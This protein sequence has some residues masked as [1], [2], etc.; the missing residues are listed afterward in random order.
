MAPDVFLPPDTPIQNA[1]EHFGPDL[2][3]VFVRSGQ[4]RLGQLIPNDIMTLLW[5]GIHDATVADIMVP[6]GT[7]VSAARAGDEAARM[8]CAQPVSTLTWA[9]ISTQ[10]GAARTQLLRT[11]TTIAAA[12]EAEVF[13][14]GGVVRALLSPDEQLQD[15]DIAVSGDFERFLAAVVAHFSADILQQS[16]FM[17]A[18]VALPPAAATAY[19]IDAFDIVGLR[20]EIYD[21]IGA[22]PLVESVDTI[23]EDLHRRD[24]TIN[25]MAIGLAQGDDLPLYDPYDGRHDLAAKR[26]VFLHPVSLFQD[27]T[28]LVR[29][30]RLVVRLGLTVPTQT[31]QQVRFAL[32]HDVL[33]AVSHHRWLAEWQRC[34]DEPHA[35]EIFVLLQAWGIRHLLRGMLKARE[36]WFA[37]A[38]QIPS[39][40]RLMAVFWHIP[41]NFM[42]ELLPTWPELPAYMPTILALRKARFSYERWL[43]APPSQ[44]VARLRAL[45]Q[46]ALP[47]VA[48]LEPNFAAVLTRYERLVSEGV[49]YVTGADLIAAGQTPG[50]LFGLYLS[51]MQRRVYADAEQTPRLLA[52]K[53]AQLAMLLEAVS[54]T[55]HQ[56]LNFPD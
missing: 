41:E 24:L 6:H 31:K 44:L 49:V 47:I 3:R 29:M 15:L 14:V 35:Y 48:A 21:H 55:D 38:R 28:R 8:S 16:P 33:H 4:R 32:E 36:A 5:F 56:F 13:L 34:V 42:A 20:S 11:L 18:T 45:H 53:Q 30:A 46:D 43:V 12:H 22:L 54:K 50:P 10:L 39:A 2:N 7:T 17:T 1:L 9:T 40:H 51:T 52:T 25:A 19:A 37:A 26:A 23:I 27:P